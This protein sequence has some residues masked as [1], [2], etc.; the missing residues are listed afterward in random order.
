MWTMEALAIKIWMGQALVWSYNI[1]HN[2]ANHFYTN[3][4]QTL[5]YRQNLCPETLPL[6]PKLGKFSLCN[7]EGALNIGYKAVVTPI[8]RD[9][10]DRKPLAYV[11]RLLPLSC[12]T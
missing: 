7:I 9:L 3:Q 8:G 10:K 2:D 6:L 11:K 5:K 1:F 4:I 12:M